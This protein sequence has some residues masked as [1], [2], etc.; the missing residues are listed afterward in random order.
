MY[1][2]KKILI[3]Q[4]CAEG[5]S[6]NALLAHVQRGS[7]DQMIRMVSD[8]MGTLICERSRTICT[9]KQNGIC[10]CRSC[11]LAVEDY[12]YWCGWCCNRW[13]TLQPHG[14]LYQDYFSRSERP[15]TQHH[16]ACKGEGGK[17]SSSMLHF[18]KGDKAFSKF[19]QKF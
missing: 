6:N 19:Y 2:E 7:I 3:I 5:W 10:A 8:T 16:S 13:G 12:D 15:R 14:I 11:K 18:D 17:K 9:S 1:S 4:I